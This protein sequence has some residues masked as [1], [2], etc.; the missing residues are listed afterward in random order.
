MGDRNI[1]VEAIIHIMYA[2]DIN[3]RIFHIAVPYLPNTTHQIVHAN[4]FFMD[5]TQ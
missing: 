4:F 1:S 3:I 2:V 5:L